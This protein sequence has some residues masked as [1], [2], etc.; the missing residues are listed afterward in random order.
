[1]GKL[2][3]KANDKAMKLANASL[4]TLFVGKTL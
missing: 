3:C 2:I 1:M 4:K